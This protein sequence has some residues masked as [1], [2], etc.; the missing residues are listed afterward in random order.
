MRI[1]KMKSF[2]TGLFVV[3]FTRFRYL[4]Q[5]FCYFWRNSKVYYMEREIFRELRRNP[6]MALGIVIFKLV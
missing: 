5:I 2:S 6:L 4:K 1:I 3:R